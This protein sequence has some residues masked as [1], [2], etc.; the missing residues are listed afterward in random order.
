MREVTAKELK[1]LDPKRFES[2][3]YKW[4][5]YA[6]DYEWWDCVEQIFTDRMAAVGTRVD[7]VYFSLSHSQDDH[8]GFDGRVDVSKWMHHNKF[9]N[10]RTFA[11]AFPALYLAVVQDGGYVIITS[12]HRRRPD[13]DYQCHVEY[14]DPEGVFQHLDEEAWR[15]LLY[16]QQYDADLEANVQAWVDARGDELYRELQ[17]EYDGISSEESFIESCEC[18]EV[19]FEIEV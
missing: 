9:D 19:T 14:T 17:E 12:N 4:L 8:A 11:E 18:N 7:R 2:E 10:E 6:H 5:T 3:Y 13:L 16:D 15:D 1:E